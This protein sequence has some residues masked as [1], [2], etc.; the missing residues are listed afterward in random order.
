M[1]EESVTHR[2]WNIG[3]YIRQLSPLPS[4]VPLGLSFIRHTRSQLIDIGSTPARSP[5][6]PF[7]PF[8]LSSRVLV[9][10]GRKI[11][12]SRSRR[13]RRSILLGRWSK[14]LARVHE[15]P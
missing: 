6:R 12:G 7:A 13:E 2:L 1:S 4:P 9:G 15:L 8:E 10:S 14:R 3:R 5:A 11:R